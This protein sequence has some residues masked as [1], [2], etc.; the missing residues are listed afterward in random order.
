MDYTNILIK[1][2]KIVRSINIESKRVQKNY[3]ISI[4]QLLTLS[5]LDSSENF[6]A[7]HKQISN[8]IE[9]NSS[10]TTGI[11]DRLEKKG[12]VA[13]LPKKDDKRS[14][15]IALTSKGESI[16]KETPPLL[17]EKLSENLES[18]S[19]EKLLEINNA[20]DIIIDFFGII[21]MDASPVIAPEEN[22]DQEI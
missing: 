21:D 16:Y 10:T 2:R 19:D 13:R 7:T 20:L 18:L 6:Q 22:L 3:G 15:Y 5:F 1:I 4:P 14:T 8:F 11:I 17:H 9:L 12:L